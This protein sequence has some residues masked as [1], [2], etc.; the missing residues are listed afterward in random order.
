MRGHLAEEETFWPA[1]IRRYGEPVLNKITDQLLKQ[2]MKTGTVCSG[3]H[4][5]TYACCHP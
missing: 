4:I 2:S 5:S 1:E 3:T